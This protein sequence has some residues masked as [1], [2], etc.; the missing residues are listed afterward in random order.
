MRSG[1][2]AELANHRRSGS[3]HPHGRKR[4][5][6]LP[7]ESIHLTAST[8]AGATYSWTGPTFVSASQ[9]PF[10][11]M[12]AADGGTYSVTVTRAAACRRPERLDGVTADAAAPTVTA[13]PRRTSFNPFA[14][15]PPGVPAGHERTARHLPRQRDGHG[16]LRRHSDALTPQVAL[17]DVTGSTCFEVGSTTVTFRFRTRPERR[18]DDRERDRPD[19]RDLNLDDVVDPSD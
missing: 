14:A 1:A 15:A 4:G 16:R 12:P 19:V 18:H 5:H 13:P 9:N 10:V 3:R 17:A 11:Q 2:D 6:G 8:V 7:G